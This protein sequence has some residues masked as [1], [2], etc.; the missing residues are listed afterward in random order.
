MK[1]REIKGQEQGQRRLGFAAL[2]IYVNLAFRSRN[3][4]IT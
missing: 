3:G 2:G 1:H 4:S